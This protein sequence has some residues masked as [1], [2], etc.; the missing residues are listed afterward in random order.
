MRRICLCCPAVLL[1]AAAYAAEPTGLKIYI[2]T[3][4]EGASGVYEFA[5]TLERGTPLNQQACEYLME[6]QARKQY[7]QFDSPSG[8]G[9]LM[10]AEAE[11]PDALH[12]LDL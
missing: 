6:D 1:A 9:K 3:D 8:P 2:N 4:L 12:I 7:L 11:I 10:T 5:Q